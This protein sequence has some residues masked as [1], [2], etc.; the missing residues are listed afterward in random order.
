M[1]HLLGAIAC[2][3]GCRAKVCGE[4]AW[5]RSDV[6]ARTP[7]LL[8]GDG[9]CGPVVVELEQILGGGVQSPFRPCG[10]SASSSELSEAAVVLDLSEGRLDR[11]RALV[12]ERAAGGLASTALMNA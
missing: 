9:G 11:L 3:R 10:G 4:L 7:G 6:S 8:S 12:K 1:S 2:P 5:R